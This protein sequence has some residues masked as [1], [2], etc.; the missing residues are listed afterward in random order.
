MTIMHHPS[1]TTLAAF[2][3]G[4]LD[5]A[6][7]LVVATHLSRCPQ[8]RDAVRTFESVGGALLDAAAPADL[9]AGALDRVLAKLGKIEKLP[10]AAAP[11]RRD[12][13]AAEALPVPL[14][15]YAMGPWRWLGRGIAWR[16]VDVPSGDAVRVFM[17]KAKPG[18]KLPKHRHTGTEWT[19]VF[20]GAFRHQLGRYG[21][22]DFDEADE[23]VEHDPVVEEGDTCICLVALQGS[24]E[25]Q[26]F[27]GR[28]LQP[29]VRI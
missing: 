7:A 3:S 26:G 21:A 29:L 8:C 22:G 17:L 18:T 6:R 25:L 20:Q 24:I 16:A 28:L 15:H 11:V 19:C 14:S 27:F 23:S 10:E 9:S 4:T 2:A 5:E 1:D 13:A 12:L